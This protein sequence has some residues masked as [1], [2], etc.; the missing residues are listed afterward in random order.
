MTG[1]TPTTFQIRTYRSF[2]PTEISGIKLW[3]DAGDLTGIDGSS[4]N[5]WLD[6]SGNNAHFNQ[7]TVAYQPILKTNQLNSRNVVR[8]DGV[9]DF[10]TSTDITKNNILTNVGGASIIA[11][12]KYPISIFQVDAVFISSGTG[13]TRASLIKRT[14]NFLA[15]TNRR[16]DADTQV[17]LTSNFTSSV[18][19]FIQ[20]GIFDYA[21][22]YGFLYIN[23]YKNIENLSYGTIGSTSNTDSTIFTIGASTGNFLNGDIAEV[24][25]FNRVLTTLEITNVNEY[26][27]RKYNLTLA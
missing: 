21:N 5:S 7:T 4:V 22:A 13:A 3:L 23:G 1:Y 16:L 10:L 24:M 11:V 12:I 20:L 6:K 15:M 2:E 27:S 25:V 18:N 26:L 17:V 8:F 9:N 14:T 19:F